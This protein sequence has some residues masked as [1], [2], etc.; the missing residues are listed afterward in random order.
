MS[1]KKYHLI[2]QPLWVRDKKSAAAHIGHGDYFGTI[3]TVLALIKQALIKKDPN[4]LTL[5]RKTLQDLETE[6]LFLQDNYLIQPS[7]NNPKEKNK[8][9][10]PKGKLTNQ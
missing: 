10:I 1:N 7:Y 5:I 4:N 3:A 6:L 9:K 8:N 2:Y